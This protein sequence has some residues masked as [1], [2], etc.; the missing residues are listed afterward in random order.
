LEVA[1]LRR[2]FSSS[3]KGTSAAELI[4]VATQIGLVCRPLKLDVDEMKLLALPAILHWD[5]QHY[6][7]LA[8]IKP[9][10]GL[11]NSR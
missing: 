2:Q 5:M 9:K 4:E 11:H 10:E 8:E 1:D 6:V 7:V 3:Q